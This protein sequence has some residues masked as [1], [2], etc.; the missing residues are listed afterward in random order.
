M[1]HCNDINKSIGL[2]CHQIQNTLDVIV[3]AK[4][5]IRTRNV[6]IHYPKD[7]TNSLKILHQLKRTAAKNKN[8]IRELELYNF[9]WICIKSISPSIYKVNFSTIDIYLY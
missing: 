4:C 9:R 8:L 5:R 7:V 6:C 2:F 1:M 3:Y